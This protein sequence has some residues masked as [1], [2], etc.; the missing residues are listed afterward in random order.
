MKR[1]VNDIIRG[2]VFRQFLPE[3]RLPLA[4]YFEMRSV[5]VRFVELAATHCPRDL[6]AFCLGD[7]AV[8][9]WGT[10]H[11]RR[12]SVSCISSGWHVPCLWPVAEEAMRVAWVL[13]ALNISGE[14]GCEGGLGRA[15]DVIMKSEEGEWVLGHEPDVGIDVMFTAIVFPHGRLSEGRVISCASIEG[16]LYEVVQ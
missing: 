15:L 1:P 14:S 16:E 12:Y 8:H 7:W 11:E 10:G 13:V 6:S 4:D 5:T 2:R 3:P 9:E